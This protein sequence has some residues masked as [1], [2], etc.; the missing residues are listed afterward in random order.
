MNLIF[1]ELMEV[2]IGYG[3]ILLVDEVFGGDLF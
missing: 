1:V 3:F 2:E